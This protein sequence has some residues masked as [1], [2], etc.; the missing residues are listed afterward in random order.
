MSWPSVSS[1]STLGPVDKRC[2]LSDSAGFSPNFRYSSVLAGGVV[3]ISAHGWDD[4]T[5]TACFLPDWN[6]RISKFCLEPVP[7]EIRTTG[8]ARDGFISGCSMEPPV[9]IGTSSVLTETAP[10]N[11]LITIIVIVS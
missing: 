11:K 9:N 2:G 7:A 6:Y 5:R 1:V 4:A 8:L 10:L 3:A